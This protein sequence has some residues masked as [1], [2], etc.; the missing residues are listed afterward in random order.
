MSIF[1]AFQIFF[2]RKFNK[3]LTT[4]NKMQKRAAQ[5]GFQLALYLS[6]MITAVSTSPNRLVRS[7]NEC[8][9][10]GRKTS[11]KFF[12]VTNLGEDIKKCFGREFKDTPLVLHLFLFYITYHI[13]MS[14]LTCTVYVS[15]S[16]MPRCMISSS[17]C[18]LVV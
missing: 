1:F 6:V 10:R 5:T 12:P 9:I 4:C 13:N 7:K 11:R 3:S 18:F 14:S 17:S 15:T 2:K 8:N 16:I